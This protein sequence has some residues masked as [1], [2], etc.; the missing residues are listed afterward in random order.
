MKPEIPLHSIGEAAPS[1]IY[2]VH[3]QLTADYDSLLRDTKKAS[4]HRDDYYLFLL[5]E[6]ADDVVLNIDFEQVR[7]G[8]GSILYI[9]PAQVHSISSFRSAGGW[10]MIIDAMLVDERSKAVL[11][12]PF[13]AQ[14]P[15]VPAPQA[16]ADMTAAA[17]LL[18]DTLARRRSEYGDVISFNLANALIGM[19]AEQYA[20]SQQPLRRSRP[21]QIGRRFLALLGDNFRTMKKPS[22]YAGAMNCSTA[23]LSESVR[24]VTG[25]S[26]GYW[27]RRQ[28]I[29]EAKRMLYHTDMDVKQIA[30]ALGY[31]DHA[32][33]S[34]LFTRAAG[35]SPSAFRRRFRE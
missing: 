27:I 8:G 34:H 32:Y 4:A 7:L 16:F 5:I 19:V 6:Q 26:A 24:K 23:Y 31:D 10:F 1:G 21:E 12:R 29:L 20:D 13:A 30:F 14:S 28:I 25:R 11:E 18:R 9:R 2:C 33:F 3:A 15:I 17:R 35:E 22:Q